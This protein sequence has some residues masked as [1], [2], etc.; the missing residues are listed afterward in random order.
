M[1]FPFK[2]FSAFFSERSLRKQKC[3]SF[4]VEKIFIKT[5]DAEENNDRHAL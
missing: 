1:N 2:S 4:L 3:D 5:I